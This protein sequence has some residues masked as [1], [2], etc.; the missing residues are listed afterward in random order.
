MYVQAHTE[1]ARKLRQLQYFSIKKY[2]SMFVSSSLITVVLGL[3]FHHW[4]LL[5]GNCNRIPRQ[6]NTSRARETVSWKI[7]PMKNYRQRR[8]TPVVRINAGNLR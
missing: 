3:P 8:E 2:D 7:F 1:H 4:K 5:R 6:N